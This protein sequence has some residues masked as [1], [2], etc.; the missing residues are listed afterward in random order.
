VRDF[1]RQHAREL[2]F[3]VGLQNEAGVDEHETA[4]QGEGV[5]FVGVDDL[6]AEWH[7]GIGVVRHV[8]HQAVDV[9]GDRGIVHHFGL[10]FGLL[11]HL[12]PQADLALDG[13][14][15]DPFA[16]VA[17]P[18]LVGIVFGVFAFGECARCS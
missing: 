13:V 2:G 14:E 10:A 7:L 18:D 3:V 17:I 16:D 4:G 6:N 5:D 11:G 12:F 15:V 9:L 1:V 8:L